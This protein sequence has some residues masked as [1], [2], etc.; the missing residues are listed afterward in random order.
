MYYSFK[1]WIV[2]G[3][4]TGFLKPAPGTWGS[5]L[6]MLLFAIIKYYIP[7]FITIIWILIFILALLWIGAVEEELGRDAPQIVIDEV[8]GVG[9][10]FL[11]I[12]FNLIQWLAAFIFFRLFD[13]FK[14][15]GIY[16]I[17]EMKGANGVIFDDI[18]AG[19]YSLFVILGLNYLGV[20]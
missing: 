4:G 13:I 5:L 19:F 14:P 18:L 11:F 8:L 17:Q 12:D 1:K 7:Q 6:G 3:L 2:C 16:Q 9:L 10:I 20:L 15:F